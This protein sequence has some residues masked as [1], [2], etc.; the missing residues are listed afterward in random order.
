MRQLATL[1]DEQGEYIK[2]IAWAWVAMTMARDYDEEQAA[3]D[4]RTSIARRDAV[5]NDDI[6]QAEALANSIL[7]SMP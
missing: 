5:T 7:Q 3:R 1:Y 4:L 2:A 6:D